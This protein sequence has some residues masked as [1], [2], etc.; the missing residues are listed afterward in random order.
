L[1]AADE[2]TCRLLHFLT[3]HADGARWLLV[4]TCRTSGLDEST[5]GGRLIAEM[6][7]EP[8]AQQLR[9][10]GLSEDEVEAMVAAEVGG[11]V[12][13]PVWRSLAQATDGHPLWI[14]EA[15]RLFADEGLID[16]GRWLGGQVVDDVPIPSTLRSVI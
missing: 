7:R 6:L 2:P 5:P 4:A 13:Q 14:V 8:G 15:L 10:Q 12:P 3:R 16:A 11:D 9:L 1:H